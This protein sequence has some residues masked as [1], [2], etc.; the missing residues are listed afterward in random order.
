MTI[1]SFL[2]KVDESIANVADMND[3]LRLT[4]AER[5]RVVTWLEQA[6]TLPHS[7]ELLSIHIDELF[8]RDLRAYGGEHAFEKLRLAVGSFVAGFEKFRELSNLGY[9]Y[10]IIELVPPDTED[11]LLSRA[12][13]NV[14]EIVSQVS[15][16][17]EIYCAHV[18]PPSPDPSEIAK[19]VAVHEE[20]L[21]PSLMEIDPVSTRVI[22]REVYRYWDDDRFRYLKIEFSQ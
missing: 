21:H 14:Q 18:P 11:E 5:N 17:P 12:P 15:G 10:I 13:R 9:L 2:K 4:N 19:R 3:A 1:A 16:V 8:D 22:Y 20:R 7:N 6:Q